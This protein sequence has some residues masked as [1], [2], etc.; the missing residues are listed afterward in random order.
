MKEKE[1]LIFDADDTLW[2]CQ[3][4]FERVM[5][6]LYTLLEPWVDRD[7]AAKQ[8][9][10]T[11][12][13]NMP[14]LGYGTKAFTLSMIE[15]ALRVSN[16]ELSGHKLA[17]LQQECYTLQEL[18]ATPLPEVEDT[19]KTL[20]Q[21]G[22]HMAVFT[23]GELLDQEHKLQRS[24]LS[25]Y[26]E[27]V[28]ITSDKTEREFTALC[29]H[30]RTEPEQITMIGNSMKSDIAPALAIGCRAV[31]IPFHVTWQ[32]EHAE[33]IQHEG[34]TEISHFSELLQIVSE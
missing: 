10:A 22:W 1:W 23:K 4:H 28:E 25:R 20:H 14:L 21:Q 3:G 7:T 26:F 13:K 12:Q 29:H 5:Q 8:L 6:E 19:L 24:G 32:L 31:Y 33:K 30:L 9:F 16:H 15:T 17:W 18:P 2:D 27:H 34:L 11:E